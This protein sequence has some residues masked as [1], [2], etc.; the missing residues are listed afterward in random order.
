MSTPSSI[1]L[2]RESTTIQELLRQLEELCEV[3]N[4]VWGSGEDQEG[5]WCELWSWDTQTLYRGETLHLVVRK[6]IDHL[7]RILL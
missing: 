2:Y 4:V 5:F 6:A 7:K 3:L 1:H